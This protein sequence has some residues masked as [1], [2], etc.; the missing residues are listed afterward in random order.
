MRKI[1]LVIPKVNRIPAQKSNPAAVTGNASGFH[2]VKKGKGS[3]YN[4]HPKHK[5]G[6]N[7][8]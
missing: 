2:K 6:V 1:S 7:E 8:N 4:R 5:N 3:K